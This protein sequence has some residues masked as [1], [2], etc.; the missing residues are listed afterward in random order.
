[1]KLSEQQQIFTYNVSCF[2][3]YAFDAHGIRLTLGEAYRTSSQVYLYFYG[4]EVVRGGILGIKLRKV[5]RLSRTL[6]SLHASRLAI[7]FN[8]FIDGKLTYDFYDIKPLGDYWESLHEEN[9]WGGDFNKNDIKD[10][11]VD[12]PHIQM[13]R[14]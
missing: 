13:N 6:R 14:I 11:F 3:Q 2:I 7:D 5:R 12:T 8:Y 10:G 1:M 9:V 4:Y